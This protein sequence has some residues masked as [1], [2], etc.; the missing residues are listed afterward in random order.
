MHGRTGH[1]QEAQQAGVSVW[2]AAFMS[3]TTLIGLSLVLLLNAVAEIYGHIH[4]VALL[5]DCVLS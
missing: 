3:T 2:L 4:G 5:P 1:L